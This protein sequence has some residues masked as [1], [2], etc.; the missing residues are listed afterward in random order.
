M[1]R[2]ALAKATGSNIETIRYYEKIGLL[3]EPERTASGHRLYSLDDEKRLKFILRCREL[4]FSI[5]ELREL[6]GLVDTDDYT[7]GDV[8]AISK[9]H[10]HDIERKIADLKRLK[11]TLDQMSAECSGDAVPECPLVDALFE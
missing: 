10:T 5:A 11:R 1:K 2:G 4:G 9:Q 7:C 8:L 3:P 6:L